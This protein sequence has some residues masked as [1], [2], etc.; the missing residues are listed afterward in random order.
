MTELEATTLR[1]GD[2]VAYR[3]RRQTHTGVIQDPWYQEDRPGHPAVR[4]QAG[5]SPRVRLRPDRLSP[6]GR[7]LAT[8]YV[9]VSS[10]VSRV[11]SAASANVYADFLDEVG[12]SRAAEKLRRAFPIDPGESILAPVKQT[13][14]AVAV[15][16]CKPPDTAR[17][18]LDVLDDVSEQYG[19]D[20]YHDRSR[21]NL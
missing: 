3:V 1:V 12:E 7:R 5:F 4:Y 17:P 19:P 18:L 9:R 15:A 6:S 20:F 10:L 11:Y 13:N 2:R 8:T 14:D 21:P 16:S